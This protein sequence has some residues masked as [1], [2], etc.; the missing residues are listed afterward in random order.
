MVLSPGGHCS[1]CLHCPVATPALQ[2]HL[3]CTLCSCV[4]LSHVTVCGCLWW[5]LGWRSA[6]I[7]PSSSGGGGTKVG[8]GLTLQS[9]PEKPEPQ[10]P[11][12][13]HTVNPPTSLSLHTTGQV[14]YG[15]CTQSHSPNWSSHSFRIGNGGNGA[16]ANIL[17]VAL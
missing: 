14:G 7:S 2:S 9:V 15:M 12:H 3:L 16:S 17:L 8:G 11:Q 5:Q 10:A 13:Q 4:R 1:I 6:S